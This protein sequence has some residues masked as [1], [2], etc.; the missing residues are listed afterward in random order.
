MGLLIPVCLLLATAELCFA[1][2][3]PTRNDAEPTASAEPLTNLA[4]PSASTNDPVV[5]PEPRKTRKSGDRPLKRFAAPPS[6]QPSRP[7]AMAKQRAL[8]LSVNEP[9]LRT[10]AAGVGYVRR[11]R[12]GT[13]PAGSPSNTTQKSV[14]FPMLFCPD[15]RTTKT[16]STAFTGSLPPIAPT[17]PRPMSGWM[18]F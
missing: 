14:R 8:I 16:T 15:P 6:R 12:T 5:H 17:N 2:P 3:L 9:S 13:K 7:P 11:T 4:T 18:S 1:P 10:T